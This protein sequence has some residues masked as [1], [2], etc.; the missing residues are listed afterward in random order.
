MK[1]LFILV[2]AIFPLVIHAQTKPDFHSWA[3]TPPM[4]WNSWDCFGPTVTEAEVKVWCRNFPL[5]LS[6]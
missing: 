6:E 4:G 1:K 5:F 2:I 3:A